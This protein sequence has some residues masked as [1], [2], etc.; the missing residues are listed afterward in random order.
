MGELTIAKKVCKWKIDEF[1]H[2]MHII[3]RPA[4]AAAWLKAITEHQHIHMLPGLRKYVQLVHMK[5]S[6]I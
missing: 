3:V 6:V 5:L 4:S 1:V 2:Q